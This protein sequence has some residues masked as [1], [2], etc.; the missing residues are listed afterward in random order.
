LKDKEERIAVLE[1]ELRISRE[2]VTSLKGELAAMKKA[3]IPTTTAP[4]LSSEIVNDEPKPFET[5]FVNYLIE[6]YLVKQDF[7]MTAMTFASEVL[8]QDLDS[9]EDVGVDTS[10]PP[11][12]IAFYRYFYNAGPNKKLYELE[13]ESRLSLLLLAFLSF[14]SIL[15]RTFLSFLSR[16]QSRR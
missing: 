1:Y 4:E 2:D 14:Q 9:F 15:T 16:N 3:V 10:D 11:D 13:V 7:K 5:R 6:K 8:D 12:L